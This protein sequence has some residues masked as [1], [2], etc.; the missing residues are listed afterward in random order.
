MSELISVEEAAA[1]GVTE[2][3]I[4]AV[5]SIDENYRVPYSVQGSN[6][7]R[8]WSEKADPKTLFCENVVM[9]RELK[10]GDGLILVLSI[11]KLLGFYNAEPGVICPAYGKPEMSGAW[12]VVVKSVIRPTHMSGVVVH[13]AVIVEVAES[14]N[15]V[16]VA[17]AAF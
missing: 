9:R 16:P 3:P 11:A 10:V 12:R 5:A 14:Y 4:A 15:P 7:L 13:D 1:Q 17:K 2:S 6:V 8:F